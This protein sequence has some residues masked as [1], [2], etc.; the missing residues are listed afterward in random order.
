MIGFVA[1]LMLLI[2]LTLVYQLV[3]KLKIVGSGPEEARL[4]ALARELQ[5]P[6]EFAGPK[7]GEELKS[8]VANAR[9]IIV[10][11]EWY[12]NSPLVI[13]EAFALGKPVIGA[14]IGGVT[15]LIQ[16][17]EDGYLFPAGDA[18]KLRQSIEMLDRNEIKIHKFGQA[19][20]RKAE[21]RFAPEKHYEILMGWYEELLR[22]P[23][24]PGMKN[25]RRLRQVTP[26]ESCEA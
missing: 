8:I 21:A 24:S 15:E 13:Y 1:V 22:R 14:D 18:E 17:G 25:N 4:K 6:V 19:A 9:F 3:S 7:H 10:P 16:H 2:F 23:A 26:Q 11:S 20:R 12:E 5:V